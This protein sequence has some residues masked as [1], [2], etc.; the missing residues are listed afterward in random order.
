MRPSFS[1]KPRRQLCGF[2]EDEREGTRS[3]SDLVI[4]VV[5]IDVPRPQTVAPDK[6][7]VPRR[8]LILGVTRQ[9]A[10]Q[11]HTH[12]L[13]VLHR[14]PSLLAKEVETDDTVR[15]YVRVYRYWSVGLLDE[16]HFRR[17]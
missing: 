2:G 11:R 9:H 15:V 7:L 1:S 3:H 8:A 13:N 14:A 6:F 4:V 5:E 10:L 17:F 16:G 12:A